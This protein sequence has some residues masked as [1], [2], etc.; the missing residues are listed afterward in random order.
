MNM[1]EYVSMFDGFAPPYTHELWV[2]YSPH[3]TGGQS[4]MSAIF[5]IFISIVICLSYF[6]EEQ[7][8][9]LL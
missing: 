6:T 4:M 9:E 8:I 1:C 2:N 7:N 5:K 3:P